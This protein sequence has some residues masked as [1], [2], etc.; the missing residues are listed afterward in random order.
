MEAI[1]SIRKA[2]AEG[3]ATLNEAESKQLLQ[4][5][6]VPVV[7]GF[8]A[9]NPDEAVACADSTGFPVVLKGLGAR[10]TH[11][12]ERGIVKLNLNDAQNVRRA[13]EDIADAAG[14]DLEGFIVQPML[15]GRREFVAG[16]FR[17]EQFGPV[18]MFGLG[19]I[20]TEALNDVTFRPAPLNEAGANSMMDDLRSK[21]LLQGWRGEQP[22]RRDQVIRVLLGLSRLAIEHPEIKEVDLNP[23]LVNAAGNVFAVDALV[24]L[25]TQMQEASQRL[26]VDPK[27]IHDLIHPRSIAFIGAS[28]TFGKWGHILFTN[29]AAGKYEGVI[30]LVNAKGG[31]IAGRP[32]FK[33][34]AD[35]PGPVDLAIVTVPAA[36]VLEL[37]PQFK[38]RG[39]KNILVVTSGFSE[40][41]EEG[42]RLEEKLVE[43]ARNAGLFI[44]GPNTMGISNPY[45]KL[46]CTYR[47]GR[48]EPGSTA[49]ITQS[50]GFANRLLAF[51]EH[52]GTGLRTFVGS[53]NE[54]MIGIEDYMEGFEND[55]L[56]KTLVLYVESIKNG[57][58][59]F[60]LSRRISRKKPII[61]LKGG[62]TVDGS[63][64]AASHTGALA[65]DE[66]V[67]EAACTQAGVVQGKTVLELHDFS[68]AFSSLPLP[69]GNRVAIMTLGGGWGVVTTD[70]CSKC[71]LSVPHLPPDII[72]R[73]DK[74]LPSYWSH[75][76]PVDMVAE[77]DPAV[78][79]T[80]AEILL[81]WTGCDALIHID[82]V[83]RDLSAGQMV[84]SALA[85]DPDSDRAL[86]EDSLCLLS[87]FNTRYLEHF[88][89]LMERYG[90]PILA[91]DLLTFGNNLQ[92]RKIK[93][94]PYQGLIFP[95]PERAV[96]ALAAMYS[97]KRRRDLE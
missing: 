58:R 89:K 83:G 61:M 26:P 28:G 52:E 33:S 45:I 74:I 12:T 19:G 42:R 49:L 4:N 18:I 1:H 14:N 57:R 38:E 44:F 46:Y 30:Y 71:G 81:E 54:A 13:A 70:L 9:S 78:P 21:A 27:V 88:A 87:E 55:D 66:T 40:V 37:I 34:I 7:E 60:E 64:A 76:N 56:T 25:S 95:A 94:T 90:K 72:F 43:E 97:Y 11:K 73:I 63:R 39:I 20:L 32:A 84:E 69:A 91:V 22:V 23:L 3:R 86:L 82:I 6:G 31:K 5:Y 92:V 16:L 35:I 2:A 77:T 93:G 59:F 68:A 53:G 36:G 15:S 85:V 96:R 17:D 24:V 41:G 62:C 10:L 79:I 48:P 29:V 65:S 47:H 75:T 80:L 67:F 51:A 8:I 50:G